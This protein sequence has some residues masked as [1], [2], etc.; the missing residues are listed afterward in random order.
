[1][2]ERETRLGARV[3]AECHWKPLRSDNKSG[4]CHPCRHAR[5][6][7]GP[8]LRQYAQELSPE[9]RAANMAKGK[10]ALAARGLEWLL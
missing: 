10:A 6:T 2:R 9:E 4:I 7:K 5:K 3:C 8:V 1:M